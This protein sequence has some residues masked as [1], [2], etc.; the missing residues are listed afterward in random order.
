MSGEI[1]RRISVRMWGDADFRGLSRPQPNAQSLWI[2]LLT[3]PHT[4]PIPGLFAAT[5]E[6]LAASLKW[7]PKAFAEALAELFPKG[8][9]EGFAEGLPEGLGERSGKQFLEADWDAG[10]VWIEGA[11]KHNEPQNPNVLKSWKKHFDM[12]PE[13]DLKDKAFERLKA[14]AKAKGKAFEEAFRKAFGKASRKP[15]RNHSPNQEQEQEQEQERTERRG[16]SACPPAPVSSPAEPPKPATSRTLDPEPESELEPETREQPQQPA[17]A[18]QPAEPLPPQQPTR[19]SAFSAP[20]RSTA[21]PVLGGLRS[22]G[23]A[24][25]ADFPDRGDLPQASSA[26]HLA[27]LQDVIRAEAYSLDWSARPFATREQFAQAVT[28]AQDLTETLGVTFDAACREL[29]RASLTAAK[30]A[31]QRFGFFLVT[32][33]PRAKPGPRATKPGRMAPTRS[34]ALEDYEPEVEQ[35]DVQTLL[36]RA[37]GE[38]C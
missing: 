34:G 12:V 18:P 19:R 3:G 30:E 2:Y 35:V 11:L 25:L 13:C 9:R 32:V 1:Y 17:E 14:F 31:P 8:F 7:D 24:A 36:R 5:R 23:S 38:G 33:D 20:S 16:E 10:V 4:T 28:R 26:A 29:A 6:G 15:L 22:N 37:R 21:A 27:H